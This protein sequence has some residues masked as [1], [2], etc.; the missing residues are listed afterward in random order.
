MIYLSSRY[1][2]SDI[3]YILDSRTGVSQAAVLRDVPQQE[4]P[5]QYG[6]VY[7][8]R[9]GDRL[10]YLSYRFFGNSLE[11]WRILDANPDVLNPSQIE[12]GTAVRIP[13]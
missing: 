6:R 1:A 10:D 3:D 4:A 2:E 12:P 9:E 7:Y 13:Q 5:D 11:W 8:W